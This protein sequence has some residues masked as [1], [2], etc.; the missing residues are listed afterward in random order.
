M[1][2]IRLAT[3]HRVKG[4]EFT[5]VFLAGMTKD[6]MP[7][8]SA[9]QTDDPARRTEVMVSERCLL[10]VALTRAKKEVLITAHGQPS[11]FLA[12]YDEPR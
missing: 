8:H 7:L 3:M 4:L 9:V 6:A 1:R 2:G 10:Y 11:D 5:I 12:F